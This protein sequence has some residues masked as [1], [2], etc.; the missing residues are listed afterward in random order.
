VEATV[1]PTPLSAEVVELLSFCHRT[2][3][4]FVPEKTPPPAPPPKQATVAIIPPVVVDGTE[5]VTDV[6]PT[7]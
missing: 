2:V 1:P 3:T 5:T 6:T 7:A 4:P